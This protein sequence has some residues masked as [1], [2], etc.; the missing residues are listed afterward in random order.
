ML[1]AGT[2]LLPQHS[3]WAQGL[4]FQIHPSLNFPQLS[5]TERL[6]VFLHLATAWLK[7]T[8]CSSIWLLFLMTSWNLF[9]TNGYWVGD[10]IFDMGLESSIVQRFK[11]MLKVARRQETK[12]VINR[13]GFTKM[14]WVSLLNACISLLVRDRSFL[15]LDSFRGKRKSWK[16]IGKEGKVT[17]TSWM[18]NRLTFCM[19]YFTQ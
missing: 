7:G 15:T 17:C 11:K 8:H 2:H 19:S 3:L 12:L 5:S 1:H 16:T 6:L 9:T 14:C 4:I 10:F 13:A 18:S